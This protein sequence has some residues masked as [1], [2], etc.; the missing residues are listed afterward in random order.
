M[1]HIK[2]TIK[3]ALKKFPF[4]QHVYAGFRSWQ[5][6]NEVKKLFVDHELYLRALTQKDLGTVT[7]KTH[8]G[9]SV[10]IRQNIWDAR[11]I[12]EM[13]F[14]KPYIRHVN[15]SANPIIV[16]IGGYIGDFSIYA[17]KYLNADRV[18][19]YEPTAENFRILKQN[20]QSNAFEDRIIAVNKA[21]SNSAEIM[22]NVEIQESN[23]VHASGYW[24]PDAEH[25]KIPSIT[26][27]DVL[28]EHQLNSVDLLKVDCE[29][30]EYDIFPA[31]TDETFSSIRNIVFEYHRVDG[32]E[33]KLE[34][35]FN[36]L[37]SAGY[38]LRVEEAIV[39]ARRA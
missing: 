12:K 33:G 38:K 7:L 31:V 8:D 15:L 39:Y 11:I 10:T 17:A 1:L 30:G 19:V 4:A 35:V 3:S 2:Q 16:D 9:L 24:Y 14:D 36:R 32:F 34:L 22:L 18:I 29:G 6:V 20:I 27:S 37:I 25:R 5:D 26:L 13:F 23:E 28:A 21:V